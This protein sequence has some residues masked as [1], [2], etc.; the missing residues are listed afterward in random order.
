VIIFS[1]V[2]IFCVS[3][4][5]SSTGDMYGGAYNV[6]SWVVVVVYSALVIVFISFVGTW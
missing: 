5:S 6:F 2:G 3:T 1:V 4:V